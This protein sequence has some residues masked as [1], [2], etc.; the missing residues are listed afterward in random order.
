[1]QEVL[2]LGEEFREWVVKVYKT[3]WFLLKEET[4]KEAVNNYRLYKGG[5]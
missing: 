2:E 4:L 3:K 1:M 5:Y